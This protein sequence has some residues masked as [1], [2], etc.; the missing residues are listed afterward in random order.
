MHSIIN[1]LRPV[2]RSRAAAHVSTSAFRKPNYDCREHADAL[3]LVIYVP[4]VEASGI[5]I[6]WRGAD[7]TIT[8]RKTQFVRVNWQALHLESAQRDYQLRLRIGGGFDIDSTHAEIHRG[9]LTVTVPKS[10]AEQPPTRSR[11]VA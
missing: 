6:Q 3:K 4:G 10:V 11:H 8:A 9:I 2:T 7:L 5:E 1:P